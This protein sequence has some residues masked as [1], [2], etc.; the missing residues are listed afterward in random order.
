MTDLDVKFSKNGIRVDPVPRKAAENLLMSRTVLALGQWE[1]TREL[2]ISLSIPRIGPTFEIKLL[3]L[4]K[5]DFYVVL[6]SGNGSAG[7]HEKELVLG[8]YADEADAI[9][10]AEG[11]ASL[12]HPPTDFEPPELE[13]PPG[14]Q[15]A[16]KTPP[17]SVA[18]Y[19][20]T[21]CSF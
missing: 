2:Q 3:P 19:D 16:S 15:D 1:E 20:G 5:S 6:E 14:A 12:L 18:D 7:K 4:G 11:R 10:Y 13:L 8:I 21:T 9:R 17:S